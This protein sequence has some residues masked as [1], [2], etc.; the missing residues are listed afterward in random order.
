MKKALLLMT[1]LLSMNAIADVYVEIA[2][3]FEG[4]ENYTLNK[5]TQ[6]LE[7][8]TVSGK[9][10]NHLYIERDGQVLMEHED[11][12]GT[13]LND[14]NSTDM[15][16]LRNGKLRIKNYDLNAAVDATPVIDVTKRNGEVR[17]VHSISLSKE[18]MNAVNHEL[19]GKAIVKALLEDPS[20]AKDLAVIVEAMREGMFEM[21]IDSDAYKCTSSR[22]GKNLS[23]ET[24]S[25]VT[26]VFD[27]E[28]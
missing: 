13:D 17:K 16:L 22:N 25:M 28:E 14:D 5:E 21:D 4:K 9:Q 6:T 20:V 27:I 18:Q 15:V 24:Y 12:M 11:L 10:Y 2:V 19:L 23:C 3:E 7:G 8:T 1:L 26:L